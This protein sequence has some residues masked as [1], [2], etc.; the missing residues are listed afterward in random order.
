MRSPLAWAESIKC[1]IRLFY[2]TKETYFAV[3]TPAMAMAAKEHGI[4]AEAVAV[5]GDHG[6]NGD[7]SVILALQFFQQFK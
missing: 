2:G 4:D 1:P 7:K 5:E 6:S 3:A